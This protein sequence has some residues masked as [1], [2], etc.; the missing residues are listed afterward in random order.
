LALLQSRFTDAEFSHRV[1]RA[2]P[3]HTDETTDT[4]KAEYWKHVA[5]FLQTG[6]IIQAV[7]E[8]NSKFAEYLVLD[9][10]PGGTGAKVALLRSEVLVCFEDGIY[11]GKENEY[12]VEFGG[13]F[14]KWRAIRTSDGYPVVEKALS[15]LD[16]KNKLAEYRKAL[17][18]NTVPSAA[19]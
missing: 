2:Q 18:V 16:C 12:R 3:E 1:F 15:E 13:N 8:D 10:Y 4:L 11:V 5:R 6:S 7:W 9:V 14:H 19:A 17:V